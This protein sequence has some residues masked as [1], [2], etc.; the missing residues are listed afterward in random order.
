MSAHETRS[1]RRTPVYIPQSLL[2]YVIQS[3]GCSFKNFL[4]NI[5]TLNV[6][7]N[8]QYFLGGQVDL[9]AVYFLFD[10]I[11]F[12]WQIIMKHM[13]IHVNNS[14]NDCYVSKDSNID[15][16]MFSLIAFHLNKLIQHTYYDVINIAD[17]SDNTR[18]VVALGKV[19][20]PYVN[21]YTKQ[22]MSLMN[23][24]HCQREETFGSLKFTLGDG[25]NF[26]QYR[27]TNYVERT[28][29]DFI[30]KHTCF[31]YS[32]QFIS[33]H[34]QLAMGILIYVCLQLPCGLHHC[35]EMFRQ[36]MI[37]KPQNIISS[38]QLSTLD[39]QSTRSQE[40]KL[41]RRALELSY[42]KN[43][44]ELDQLQFDMDKLQY[45]MEELDFEIERLEYE[46]ATAQANRTQ[47][48]STRP[49]QQSQPITV[50]TPVDSY[51]CCGSFLDAECCA[52]EQS[53][54]VGEHSWICSDYR[55]RSLL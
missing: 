51:L 20:G 23:N 4:Y 53:T 18:C 36:F 38:P 9:R 27:N 17:T 37:P 22:I 21:D 16:N 47:Y 1:S 35:V 43:K 12:I 7:L 52:S 2:N 44:C 31:I 54:E 10:N 49:S 28:R 39:Y 19:L 30:V 48:E 15:Q 34:P 46:D 41:Q 26:F 45:E 14:S 55:G 8:G 33:V 3:V 24:Q 25:H 11:E 40:K 6:S 50:A 29:N 32:N 5:P 42:N 13:L